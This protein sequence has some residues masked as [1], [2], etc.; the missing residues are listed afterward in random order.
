MNDDKT[1]GIQPID[2]NQG[3]KPRQQQK[4]TLVEKG[5]DDEEPETKEEERIPHPLPFGKLDIFA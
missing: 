1:E 4:K 5:P 3:W 2:R